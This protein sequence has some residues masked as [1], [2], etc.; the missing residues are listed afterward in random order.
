MNPYEPRGRHDQDYADSLSEHYG[1]DDSRSRGNAGASGRGDRSADWQSQGHQTHYD[2][3]YEQWRAEQ[4]R[5]FDADYHGWRQE[6]YQKFSED[7]GKW[8]S[9]RASR[10]APDSVES[11]Q[12][13]RE[14]TADSTRYG[15][16]G[17]RM[18]GTIGSHDDRD[19]TLSV[20]GLQSAD[21]SGTTPSPTSSASGLS[22]SSSS[23][24][25]SLGKK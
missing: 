9:E 5:A 17:N 13:G 11:Q 23:S 15:L 22:G 12:L 14:D 8:R 18:G 7:F 4:M 10:Q 24:G 21:A 20:S 2:P 6:R 19:S 16:G 25:S 3:D 1:G